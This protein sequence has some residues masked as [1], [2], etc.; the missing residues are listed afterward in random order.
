MRHIA[1]H[2]D[3]RK[4]VV[5]P[6]LFVRF[7]ALCCSVV[8]AASL[9]LPSFAF[10]EVRKS[11]IVMGDTVEARGLTVAQC[12]S[13]DAL[14]ACVMDDSGTVYFER[15]AASAT[16]IASLTK[17]MTCVIALDAVSDGLASFDDTLSV[18]AEAAHVGESSAGLQEGDELTLD[19][20]LYALMV[21]SG[22]DA[23]IAIS[24]FIGQ[25]M[26]DAAGG[27]DPEQLFVDAMNEKAAELGCVDTV[28]RNPHGLDSGEHSGDQHSCAADQ[29]RIVK[30]GMQNERFREVVS[31]GDAVITVSRASEGDAG[32]SRQSVEVQLESTDMFFD[33]YEYACGVK[34][35]TTKLAGPSF[36][37]AAYNGERYLYAIVMHSSS[38][39][40]RFNDAETLCEWVYANLIDYS[41]VNSNETLPVQ[42]DEGEVQAPVVA[43]VSHADWIDVTI[44][45]VLSDP[46]A[47][48]ELFKLNGNVSQSIEFNEVHGNVHAG[49]VLGKVSFKQRN[50]VIAEYD[51]LAATDVAAPNFFENIGIWWDKLFRGFSGEPQTAESTVLN[52]TPLLNDK[53]SA[54]T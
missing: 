1:F 20:A 24:E 37:G 48:V 33:M 35:G 9:A 17:I 26:A 16:Q 42:T 32:S 54:V 38:E 45:A 50:Q 30:Y 4:G 28:Y 6:S 27:G 52:T 5:K 10:A 36:A 18:S 2:S 47:T 22:N 14:Y 51:L 8:L 39:A 13:I 46:D 23:A 11:D 21:P 7:T 3:A 53:S 29:A 40:Q 31:G 41:L 25:R 19:A 15:D 12:P 49:D 34:T 44:P 43:N